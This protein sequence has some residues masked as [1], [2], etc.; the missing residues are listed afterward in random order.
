MY[1]IGNISVKR[2]ITCGVT[3]LVVTFIDIPS[4]VHDDSARAIIGLLDL[5]IRSNVFW[6]DNR[7]WLLLLLKSS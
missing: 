1:V 6:Q 7:T 2:F 5:Y 3:K 4:S